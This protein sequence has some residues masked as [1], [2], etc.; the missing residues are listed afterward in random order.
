MANYKEAIEDRL[1]PI[2]DYIDATETL[3]EY[4]GPDSLACHGLRR[5]DDTHIEALFI[6]PEN[7]CG[8]QA[9]PPMFDLLRYINGEF[10]TQTDNV[11]AHQHFIDTV[12]ING[13]QVKLVPGHKIAGLTVEAAQLA[14][15]QD[16]ETP[17]DLMLAQIR[18]IR[19]KG[20][21][22]PRQDLLLAG[23]LQK[24]KQGV[25]YSPKTSVNNLV[26]V[27]A[28]GFRCVSVG[29]I[30]EEIKRQML[31]PHWL[32]ETTAQGFG[33][34]ASLIRQARDMV[35]VLMQCERSR[36]ARTIIKTG[37]LVSTR[38]ELLPSPA[39]QGFGNA[40]I[41]VNGNSYGDQQRLLV[42]FYPI[43]KI[44]EG[45]ENARVQGDP[46]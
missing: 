18:F 3:L 40:Q 23:E 20:F 34:A 32:F 41:F 33:K 29:R 4:Y 19:Y 28:N 31:L 44:A 16:R 24:D 43:E 45:I 15:N 39:E 7:I 12:I 8:P 26:R 17:E 21:V 37:D 9:R 2:P 27:D 13:V 10:T 38:F 22:L 25:L 42:R 30:E 6:V 5:I 46:A 1:G 36:F 14:Y 35:P 11:D